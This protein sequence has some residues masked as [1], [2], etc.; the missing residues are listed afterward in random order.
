MKTIKILLISLIA[1]LL[2]LLTGYKYIYHIP[3]KSF[4]VKNTSAVYVNENFSGKNIKPLEE[5]LV[6]LGEEG[7]IEDLKKEKRYIKNIYILYFGSVEYMKEQQVGILDPGLLYPVLKLK[8]GKYFDKDGEYYLLKDEYMEKYSS[9]KEIFLRGYRG[10]FVL[11][12]SK[13]KI[14]YV[15]ASMGEVNENIL[16][17]EKETDSNIFGKMILDASNTKAKLLGVTGSIIKGEYSDGKVSLDNTLVGKDGII[18]LFNIQPKERKLEKYLGENRIYVSSGNFGKAGRIFMD[19]VPEE[20]KIIFE[21]WKS[22]AGGSIEEFLAD[23]DGEIVADLGKNQWMIPLKESKRFKKIFDNLGKDN[24]ISIGN[25]NLFLDG[26]TIFQ[27]KDK[28]SVGTEKVLS[29]NQFLYGDISLDLLDSKFSKESKILIKGI[30]AEN[31]LNLH[32]ELN[33]ETL[34]DLLSKVK[35]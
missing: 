24:R 22:F 29:D 26:N 23:I 30:S 18:E 4:I 12:D 7:R 35:N 20:Q 5:L 3:G 1:F 15:L 34:D 17:L 11:S 13:D 33:E 25:I 2:V 28:I 31:S 16:T 19:G 9:G 21:I 27:G 8:L 10:H 14:E 32:M 6:K